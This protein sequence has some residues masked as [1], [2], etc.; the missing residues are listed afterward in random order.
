MAVVAAC[1]GIATVLCGRL[2]ATGM[3]ACH[4]DWVHFHTS[5]EISRR[6]LLEH[7]ALPFWNPHT[8]GGIEHLGDPQT[9]FLSP[10]FPLIVA[11]GSFLG[12]KLFAW[13]H[14]VIGLLGGV[15]LGRE[16][17][18]C[19][20]WSVAIAM[21][22]AASPFHLWHLNAGHIPF[23]QFQ[24][25]PW[26]VWSYLAA[27][28]NPAL[29][30]WG[31]AF[32][33]VAMLSGGTYVAPFAA[34]LLGAHALCAGMAERP[35]WRPMAPALIVAI[36]LGGGVALAAAK[37]LP[38]YAFVRQFERPP[39]PDEILGLEQL[40]RMFFDDTWRAEGMRLRIWEYGNFLGW[41]GA[42]LMLLAAWGARRAWSWLIV[43]ALA[44]ALTIG[45]FDPWAPYS[46]LRR[47]PVFESLRVPS[48]Y[49][50]LVVFALAMAAAAGVIAIRA[51]LDVLGARA[52]SGARAARW[53]RALHAI[54]TM[55]GLAVVISVVSY[56]RSIVPRSI[57]Q[58]TPGAIERPARFHLVKGDFDRMWQ[59]V[60]EG[61]GTT[62]CRAPMILR[63]SPALWL[64]DVEQ[65]RL[66]PP[67][68]GQA[69]VTHIGADRWRIHVA[70][71]RPAV[72]RLN[73]HYRPSFATSHGRLIET[74]GL[75]GVA[76]EAGTYDLEIAYR[77]REARIGFAISGAAWLLLLAAC[78]AWR[79]R[80]G[81]RAARGAPRVRAVLGPEAFRR[82]A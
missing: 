50:M 54:V 19:R 35:R 65:V 36:I 60:R 38:A 41:C 49:T 39:L 2:L 52:A 30:L 25:L 7:G 27:R 61:L 33:G 22:V 31:A 34:V 24:W 16:L 56:G 18:L 59:T 11:F 26:I 37:V 67:D 14:L 5:V 58:D 78:V 81:A 3:R 77:P 47:L 8:C 79:L 75:V 13:A 57:C 21:V 69:R 40:W 46:L 20:V 74:Q 23:L 63:T 10:L 70:L 17:G 76:L 62:Y 4:Q 42:L 32:L 9:E 72:L 53:R 1:L 80:R 6:S 29:A 48:R 71:T 44:L 66:R 45:S 28:R 73:Q 15:R 51:R 82:R 43:A 12:L 64:G 68:A 55:L